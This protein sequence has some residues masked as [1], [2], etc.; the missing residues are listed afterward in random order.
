MKTNWT[1]YRSRYVVID[2]DALDRLLRQAGITRHEEIAAIEAEAVSGTMH[3]GHVGIEHEIA[4][5]ATRRGI[6]IPPDEIE[7]L[8]QDVLIAS[9]SADF[10]LSD[11]VNTIIDELLDAEGAP[12]YPSAGDAESE[13]AGDEVS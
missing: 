10:A 5:E 2:R 12:T 9:A 13:E 7:R 8:T 1:S 4:E 11:T 6:V 3:M